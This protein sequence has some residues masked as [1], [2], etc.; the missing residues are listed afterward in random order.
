M[1]LHNQSDVLSSAEAARFGEALGDE[2]LLTREQAA[3]FL[4]VSP[5]TLDNWCANARS[6]K[7]ARKRAELRR[8][9]AAGAAKEAIQPSRER[10]PHIKLGHKVFFMLGDLRR[11]RDERKVAAGIPRPSNAAHRSPRRAPGLS[12]QMI[13]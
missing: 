2:R 4:F 9:R 3:Q 7:I 11:F 5:R 12:N 8:K 10:L 1:S 6:P 13:T